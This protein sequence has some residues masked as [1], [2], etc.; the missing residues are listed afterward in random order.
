[1][2]SNCFIQPGI[3]VNSSNTVVTGNVLDGP[4]Y[5]VGDKNV[6][7]GNRI[8]GS[9]EGVLTACV[10]TDAGADSTIIV[11]NSTYDPTINNGSNTKP[12]TPATFADVNIVIP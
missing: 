5:V 2:I 3:T 4:I 11:G 9:L 6:I 10:Q 12:S 8:Y 1:M 7:T